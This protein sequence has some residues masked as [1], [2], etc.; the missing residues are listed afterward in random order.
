MEKKRPVG[1]TKSKRGKAILGCGGKKRKRLL[2]RESIP[3]NHPLL[4]TSS[5]RGGVN[6]M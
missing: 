5:V 6:K 2:G 1:E 4:R 3:P